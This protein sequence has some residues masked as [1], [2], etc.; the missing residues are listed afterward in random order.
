MGIGSQ[1]LELSFQG[2]ATP[3]HFLVEA[4]QRQGF[5]RNLP[6]DGLIVYHVDEAVIGQGIQSNTVNSGFSPGLVIVE[7]DGASDLTNGINRGDAGDAF[8]GASHRYTLFDGTPPPNT[9]TF[10]GSPTNVGLFDIA[11]A[12]QGMSFLARVRAVGWEPAVDRTVG[13]YSPVDVQ[14]PA[15]TVA[16]APDGTGYSVASETRDGHQQIILRTRSGDTWDEGFAVSQSSGSALEPALTLLGAGDLAVAWRDTRLGGARVYYRARVGGTWTSEQLL[17]PLAGEHRAPSIGA[18]GKGGVYVAWLYVGLDLPRIL[19][20]RFPYLSPFGLPITLS[21]TGSSPANPL[22]AAMPTGGAMVIWTDNAAWPYTLWF[23]R[24]GPDS[25]PSPPM[26]LTEQSGYPQSWVS[27]LVE[28]SGAVHSLWIENSSTTSELHYQLRRPSGG[29]TPGDTVLESSS[30]TLAKARLVR[31]AEGG[32]HVVF[33]RSVNGVSQVRYRR[34]DP[35]LGWDAGSTD[36]SAVSDGA[37]VQPAVLAT[38]PGRVVVLY[39]GFQNGQPRFMER[40]R[41]TDSPGVLAVP[42]PVASVAPARLS[43][44][45]NPVRAGH[46]LELRWSAAPPGPGPAEPAAVEVFDLAGRRVASVDLR[47]QGSQSSGRLDAGVTRPWSAGI[48]F[49]RL[50]GASAPAQR[51]VVLR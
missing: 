43:F 48:Y 35:T 18:D 7:G 6:A 51:L 34:R 28:S 42:D 37:A 25:T 8:P 32:L 9:R 10:L 27:A 17:S 30:S 11:E 29:Y 13:E 39:R 41:T 21:R 46:D 4:R 33:E 12:P 1:V 36:I 23:S 26:T 47:S 3:E 22:V 50:R 16:R 24:C 5:D 38:T 14:T 44:R 20:M 2:E 49:V 15:R 31:D 19:Y 45:P 40:S